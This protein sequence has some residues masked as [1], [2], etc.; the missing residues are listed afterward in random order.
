M[1]KVVNI[2]PP[3]LSSYPHH[4]VIMSML[5]GKPFLLTHMMNNYIQL[6]YY[7]DER[8][9]FNIS[10]NIVEYVNNYPLIENHKISHKM[11]ENL[12]VEPYELVKI[13]IDDDYII[14]CLIDLF[15]IK[16][17]KHYECKHVY[18]ELMIYGYDDESMKFYIGE[19]F[20]GKKYDFYTVD[21]E[22][23]MKTFKNT[24]FFDWFTGIRFLRLKKDIYMGINV[25]MDMLKDNLLA[26][27]NGIN[28]YN[29]SVNDYMLR[30][31]DYTY[32]ID[33]Y[34]IIGEMVSK[35]ESIDLRAF[36]VTIEHKK[37]LELIIKELTINS[38]LNY[39]EDNLSNIR[40]LQDISTIIRNMAMI[41]VKT[42]SEKYKNHLMEKLR[43]LEAKE[44]QYF[45]KLL[46]DLCEYE[47][48]SFECDKRMCDASIDFIN[49]DYD[50]KES[51]NNK[52]GN[53]G[54]YIA[55]GCNNIPTY[56]E[57]IR[58]CKA[59]LV[60]LSLDSVQEKGIL[61]EGKKVTAYLLNSTDFEIA[62]GINESG[63][64]KISFFF[65]DYDNLG[66][67]IKIEGYDI[68]N[69]QKIYSS[70]YFEPKEGVYYSF[71]VRGNIKFKF[72]K[73][74][75]PDVVISGIFFD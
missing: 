33:I 3:F 19:Y 8:L 31:N 28:N 2:E 35:G 1:K 6:A 34:Q 26:Y 23:I 62:F 11:V 60:I 7:K 30:S 41:L 47:K 46:D 37:C 48:I 69:N 38:M 65:A 29:V 54:L 59:Y 5:T 68:N 66:R 21:Y 16:I 71:N 24:N 9:D 50:T 36:Q 25:R 49:C 72:S 44:K 73:V 61:F 40:E 27:L 15:N 70:D 12:K 43:E 55:A 64:K 20:D 10:H 39:A 17:S 14:F 57:K 51:W 56:I 58:Y 32:G 75:G 67:I 45:S 63:T 22:D 4:S 18:H 53:D 74:Q 42:H 13:M 52:Y